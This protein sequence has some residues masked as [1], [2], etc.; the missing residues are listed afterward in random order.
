MAASTVWLC[1]IPKQGQVLISSMSPIG[2]DKGPSFFLAQGQRVLFITHCY[3]MFLLL[4]CKILLPLKCALTSIF[5]IHL[6][7]GNKKMFSALRWVRRVKQHFNFVGTC[8]LCVCTEEV[9]V[10]VININD[11][12]WK[13]MRHSYTCRLPPVFL[14]SNDL[15]KLWVKLECSV[16]YKHF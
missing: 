3:I 6:C 4:F 9:C 15:V 2:R 7:W 14:C 16:W 8:P 12:G 11:G 10:Y 13:L 1:D 5:T